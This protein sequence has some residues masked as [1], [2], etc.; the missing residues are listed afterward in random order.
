[1]YGKELVNY[2]EVMGYAEA[3]AKMG[4]NPTYIICGKPGPTG[5][6]WLWN[7]LRQAGHNAIEISDAIGPFVDYLTEKNHMHETP[8]GDVVIVLNKP[9]RG[10][11]KL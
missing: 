4:R 9:L 10:A 7:A 2:R 6:T 8:F 1:M 5:K 11:W 3:K